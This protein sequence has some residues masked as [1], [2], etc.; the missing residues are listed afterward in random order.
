MTCK[1]TLNKQ[2]PGKPDQKKKD[3]KQTR[4]QLALIP[5]RSASLMTDLLKYGEVGGKLG[6]ARAK[7]M[8]LTTQ[9]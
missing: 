1:V 9:Q 4:P 8:Q 3:R 7:Y 2:Q 5:L 6:K